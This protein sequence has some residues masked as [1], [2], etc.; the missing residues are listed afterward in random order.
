[1][2]VK[3]ARKGLVVR[4]P[5]TFVVVPEKGMEV[6]DSSYWI[7]RQNDGDVVIVEKPAKAVKNEEVK[8]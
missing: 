3:P 4:C 2:F 6:P 7:R 8:K 5:L 1:M